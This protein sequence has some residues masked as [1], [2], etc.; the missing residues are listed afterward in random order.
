[1]ENLIL[2]FINK[3]YMLNFDVLILKLRGWG[4]YS[5]FYYYIINIVNI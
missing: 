3:V 1:M 2:F 4:Y 5:F